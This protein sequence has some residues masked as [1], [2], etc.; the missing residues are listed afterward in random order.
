MDSEDYIARADRLFG[1]YRGAVVSNKDPLQRARLQVV[2]NNLDTTAPVWAEPCIPY[3][4]TNEGPALP[5]PGTT[6][7]VEFEEG[8]PQRP[9]WSGVVVTE[10]CSH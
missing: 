2:F 10:R 9:V 7:W 6:V 4:D 8:N 1:K 5:P 3:S